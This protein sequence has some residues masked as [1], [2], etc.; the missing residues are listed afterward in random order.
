MMVR[1]PLGLWRAVHIRALDE[2]RP[3][4]TVIRQAIVDYLTH[5]K[6]SVV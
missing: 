3:V 5:H 1:L 6:P 4:A 2:E